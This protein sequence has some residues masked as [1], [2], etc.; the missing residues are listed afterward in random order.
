MA[1][2]SRIRARYIDPDGDRYGIPTFCW[3][4]APPGLATR[5]QLATLNLRPGGHDP[6]AQIMWRGHRRDRIALLYAIA[7][8]KP[9]RTATPR[10]RA[11]L[12]KANT[13]RRTC[14]EC[15]HIKDY[16]IP[17]RFGRCLDCEYGPAEGTA[18]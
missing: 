17:G 8:A 18:A 6:V 16:V 11:A 7:T 13:A 12:D 14:P 3:G 2:S 10:Q 9:K 5:R 1:D 15:G 4:L